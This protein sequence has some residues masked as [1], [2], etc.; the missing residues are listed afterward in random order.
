MNGIVTEIQRFS[1]N[2]GPGVRTTVFLKGCNLHCAWCHSPETQSP[3]PELQV[4]PEKCIGCG[5]C[6]RVCPTGAHELTNGVKSFKR[7]LCTNCGRCAAVCF[8]RALVMAGTAM[9]PAE[10]MVQVELDAEFYKSSGGGV[11]VSGGEPFAQRDFLIE[12]FRLCRASGVSTAV[13]TNLDWPWKT[14]EDALPLIDL[15]MVDLK[16][17]SSTLHRRWTGNGNERVLENLRRLSAAGMPIVV[18]TPVI[19]GVNDDAT[20]I[21]GIARFIAELPTL[22]YYDLL[23]YHSLGTVKYRALSRPYELEGLRKPSKETMTALRRAAERSGIA[24][25]DR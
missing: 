12:V 7:E 18:R 10:V 9:S 25:Y 14:I 6:V 4:F 21:E 8:P 19:P 17:R 2:D 15:A 3:K 24:V 23:P 11:T 13:E 5:E 1:I 16:T 20:E 22:L